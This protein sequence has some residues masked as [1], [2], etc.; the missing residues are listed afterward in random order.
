MLVQP[1]HFCMGCVYTSNL[2]L[3]S[4]LRAHISSDSN[5]ILCFQ[6][7]YVSAHNQQHN[8]QVIATNL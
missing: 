3:I 7:Q 4:T 8:L 2:V 1:C 6:V 5:S